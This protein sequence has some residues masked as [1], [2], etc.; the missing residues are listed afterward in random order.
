MEIASYSG[1]SASGP[2]YCP[3]DNKVYISRNKK[4]R[5]RFMKPRPDKHKVKT[6]QMVLDRL[7]DEHGLSTRQIYTR[8]LAHRRAER[9]KGKGR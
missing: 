1:Q 7:H 4:D 2:F 8:L 3:L 5:H 6:T 9:A